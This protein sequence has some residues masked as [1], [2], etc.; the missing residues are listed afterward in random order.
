MV[1]YHIAFSPSVSV[2]WLIKHVDESFLTDDRIR[3]YLFT[4]SYEMMIR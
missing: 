3:E 1:T 2:F 4:V